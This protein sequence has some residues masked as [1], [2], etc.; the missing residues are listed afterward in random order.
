MKRKGFVELILLAVVLFIGYGL[1]Q[2]ARLINAIVDQAEQSIR[3]TETLRGTIEDISYFKENNS[4]RVGLTFQDGRKFIFI[5]WPEE[6]EEDVDFDSPCDVV[7]N[8]Q[9]MELISIRK[10]K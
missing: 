4:E 7:F 6:F 2:K 8:L 9:T 3:H 1:Y 5:S 10:V